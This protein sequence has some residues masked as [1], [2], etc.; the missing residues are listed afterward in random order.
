MLK[1]SSSEQK[2]DRIMLAFDYSYKKMLLDEIRQLPGRSW[3]P[4]VRAWSIPIVEASCNALIAMCTRK[5][6][7]CEVEPD[8][9]FRVPMLANLVEN[10]R[11]IAA[12]WRAVGIAKNVD[13]HMRR[14]GYGIRTRKAYCGHIE[15]FMIDHGGE[16]EDIQNE[17]IREYTLKLMDAGRAHAYVNQAISALRYWLCEVEGRK[18]F[19]NKWERPR[20]QRKLPNVLSVEEVLRL[21]GAVPNMKHRTL[22]ALVYSAGLRIGEAVRLKPQDIDPIRKVIKI[23]QAKGAKDRYTVLSFAA[24]EMLKSYMKQE[25]PLH[26]LF[27]GAD[28]TK[29]LTERTIQHVFERM[30]DELGLRSTATVHTLR[31][32]FATH[33]LEEGTDLRYIQELLGHASPKTTQIYTHV[34]IRD[35]RRIQ[36]PFDRALASDQVGSTLFNDNDNDK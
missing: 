22:L 34:T 13:E 16:V 32:S 27:P 28:P 33:L 24:Y 11:S 12:E 7:D 19:P 20:R 9:L 15:R 1:I 4:E 8:L 2:T 29:H 17:Q 23:R 35:V 18:D 30:R 21:I 5:A 31:H 14:R 6:V 26:W 3:H 10:G 36:S 25:K